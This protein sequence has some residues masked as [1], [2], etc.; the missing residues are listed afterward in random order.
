MQMGVDVD[1][2]LLGYM[3]VCLVFLVFNLFNIIYKW[4]I[5]MML[6]RNTRKWKKILGK[7][8]LKLVQ[9]EQVDVQHKKRLEKSLRNI[10]Q[11]MAYARAMNK[12]KKEK[13]NIQKY[14]NE[15]YMSYQNL[16]YYYRGKDSMDKAYFA[17]FIAEYTPD[18]GCEYRTIMNILLDYMEDSTVYCRENVLKA[19]YALGNV[20]AVVHALEYIEDNQ[21]FHHQKLITDGLLSFKGDKEKLAFALWDRRFKWNE[22]IMVAIIQYITACLGNFKEIFY[23]ELQ[24]DDISIEERLSLLRY[25]QKYEYEPVRELLYSYIKEDCPEVNYTIVAATVLKNYPGDETTKALIDALHN[26]NWYVRYNAAT[27]LVQLTQDEKILQQILNGDDQYAKE[28]L[29]Y[30]LEEFRKEA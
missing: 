23:E 14:I 12:M 15:C 18:V 25:Y 5:N 26:T 29:Q 4:I 20:Q 2:I 30:K 9:G 24:E 22:T 8:I 7:Q 17:I 28:I 27:S 13:V 11:L 3:F 19:L 16:A 1:F 10:N 21:I 6:L